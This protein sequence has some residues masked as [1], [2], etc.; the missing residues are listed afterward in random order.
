MN[1]IELAHVND[2]FSLSDHD[3]KQF[4]QRIDFYLHLE[5]LLNRRLPFNGDILDTLNLRNL[6]LNRSSL[7]RVDHILTLVKLT[8]VYDIADKLM[9]I[10]ALVC[11]E[12]QFSQGLE[13]RNVYSYIISFIYNYDLLVNYQCLSFNTF[14]LLTVTYRLSTVFFNERSIFGNRF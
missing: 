5:T 13:V 4:D 8:E 11:W 3:Y 2:L 14:N 12:A 10:R 7:K 1:L 6:K 9:F